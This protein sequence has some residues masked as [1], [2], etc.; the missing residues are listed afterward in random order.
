LQFLF[1]KSEGARPLG[2]TTVVG[3]RILRRIYK[4]EDKDWIQFAQDT[5]Q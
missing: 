5:V 2:E 1:S 4:K 3:R